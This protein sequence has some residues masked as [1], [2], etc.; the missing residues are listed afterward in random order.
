MGDKAL[1]NSTLPHV[2]IALKSLTR[3]CCK[4][5]PLYFMYSLV[6]PSSPGALRSFSFRVTCSIS[7]AVINP[8]GNDTEMH[9]NRRFFSTGIEFAKNAY[10]YVLKSPSRS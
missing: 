6:I 9:E 1:Y 4:Y 2:T 8:P 5:G 10:A 3:Q 7:S